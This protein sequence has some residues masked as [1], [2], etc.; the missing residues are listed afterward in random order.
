MAAMTGKGFRPKRKAAVKGSSQA[1]TSKAPVA[2]PLPAAAAKG[3]LAALEL[4]SSKPATTPQAP[5]QFGSALL[6]PSAQAERVEVG[7]PADA[8]TDGMSAWRG[9]AKPT[10]QAEEAG[11][12]QQA[13]QQG[14]PAGFAWT[15]GQP[16]HGAAQQQAEG[17]QAAQPEAHAAGTAGGQQ[18]LHPQHQAEGWQEGAKPSFPFEVTGGQPVLH[19]HHQQALRTGGRPGTAQAASPSGEIAGQRGHFSQP[20]TRPQAVTRFQQVPLSTARS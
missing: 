3:A 20:R 16:A 12:Q 1:G 19:P 11:E 5:A 15:E 18:A 2:P 6:K 17:Q 14:P 9:S 8:K 13:A 10:S 7:A 4:P